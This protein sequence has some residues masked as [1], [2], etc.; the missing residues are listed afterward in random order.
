MFFKRCPFQGCKKYLM[1]WQRV[2][3]F[4]NQS[5]VLALSQT[6]NFGLFQTERV[7]RR[8]F[9]IRG[10]CQKVLQMSRKH[11]GKQRNCSLRAISPFSTVFSKDLNCR[12]VKTRACLG[13]ELTLSQTSTGFLSFCIRS[14]LKIL[15][16]KEKLLVPLAFLQG[17]RIFCLF[18]Q[19]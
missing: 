3:P 11:C 6:T 7:C 12:H 16:E 14:L 13:E 1:V 4:I 5:Q 18:H 8:Q 17:L 19:I 9:Q 15:W 2:N 10:D